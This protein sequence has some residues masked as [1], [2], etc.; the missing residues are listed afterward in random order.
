MCTWCGRAAVL[1][2]VVCRAAGIGE[3]EV[4]RDEGWG[5]GERV[6][7]GSPFTTLSPIRTGPG[8]YELPGVP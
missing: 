3:A 2:A 8:R 7:H 6:C 5:R 1:C 4:G